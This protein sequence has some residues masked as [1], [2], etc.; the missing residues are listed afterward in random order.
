MAPTAPNTNPAA[1]VKKA[2]TSASCPKGAIEPDCD[3]RLSRNDIKGLLG[4]WHYMEG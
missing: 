3:E 1:A 4:H 2:S